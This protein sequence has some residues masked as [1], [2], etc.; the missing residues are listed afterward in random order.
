MTSISKYWGHISFLT[1]PFKAF[2]SSQ[3]NRTS[4]S[5]THLAK[6]E[7]EDLCSQ[8]PRKTSGR[9]ERES[10]AEQGL[11]ALSPDLS[12]SKVHCCPSGPAPRVTSKGVAPQEQ[13]G[14]P[15]EAHPEKQLLYMLLKVNFVQSKTSNSTARTQAAPSKWPHPQQHR[16]GGHSDG[17]T[18]R[19]RWP[20]DRA[21]TRYRVTG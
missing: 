9:S 7:T 20:Q 12:A 5:F 15:P 14:K 6:R 8:K 13:R 1:P 18:H 11:F 16:E 4:H 2:S 3:S 21:G 10:R 19:G 17:V